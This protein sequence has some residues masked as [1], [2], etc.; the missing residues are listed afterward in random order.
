[1]THFL[2]YLISSVHA[3][4]DGLYQSLVN[5]SR[6]LHLEGSENDMSAAFYHYS[7]RIIVVSRAADILTGCVMDVK[8]ITCIRDK[9]GGFMFSY[10]LLQNMKHVSCNCIIR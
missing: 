9:T 5:L 2:S 10:T 3:Y 7:Q 6:F 1:M 8:G 4:L